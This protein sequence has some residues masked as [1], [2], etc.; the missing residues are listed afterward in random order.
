MFNADSSQSAV[1]YTVRDGVGCT[2]QQLYSPEF[3]LQPR[4]WS[5][6]SECFP[7]CIISSMVT[8][9]ARYAT[10]FLPFKRNPKDTRSHKEKRH[11]P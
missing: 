11:H 10:F 9:P 7:S 5:N 4:L 6:Q 3:R 2:G 8:Q 1:P